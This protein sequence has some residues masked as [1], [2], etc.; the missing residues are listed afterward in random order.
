MKIFWKLINPP[1]LIFLLLFFLLYSSGS[2]FSGTHFRDDHVIVGINQHLQE[3]NFLLTLFKEVKNEF[4]GDGGIFSGTRFRPLFVFH[5]IVITKIFGINFLAWHIY[6]GFLA[7]LTAYFLY[8][9]ARLVRLRPKESFIFSLFSTLGPQFDNGFRLLNNET[10][11]I[12][13]LSISLVFSALG[14][15]YKKFSRQC[16]FL[17]LV[18]T[19]LMSLSKESFILFIP[20]LLYIKIWQYK[21]YN[22]TSWSST[23]R[24]NSLLIVALNSIFFL[25]S[26]YI[27]FFIGTSVGYAGI[28]GVNFSSF[29]KAAYSIT[30]FSFPL[31]IGIGFVFS[32]LLILR[33]CKSTEDFYF[34]NVNALTSVFT[35]FFLIV[36]PQ[37]ILYS[38]SDFS[39]RYLV[40]GILGYSFLLAF[41]YRF[42][43]DRSRILSFTFSILML[44]GIA[45][46]FNDTWKFS[47]QDAF[48]SKVA[49]EI[50]DSVEKDTRFDSPILVV[51]N[52]YID[53][54]WTHSIK[55][56][57]SLLK[58]RNNLYLSTYGSQKAD[59]LT[60]ALVKD[61]ENW[62]FLDPEDLNKS[63]ANRN[64]SNV[65]EKIQFQCIIVP[66]KLND[67]F[68][69]AS[70]EWFSFGNYK[71]ISYPREIPL[72]DFWMYLSRQLMLDKVAF[73]NGNASL[74]VNFILYIRKHSF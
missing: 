19:V 18:F 65:K 7:F 23:I 63:Y 37:I 62:L 24:K 49:R 22:Q 8:V 69:N 12:L 13:F 73:P 20:A 3:N 58:S 27:K 34:K 21:L 43:N 32:F 41:L 6:I 39:P 68:L 51:S 44:F 14:L 61:E 16:E 57:L 26:L 46:K 67:I 11:G 56:Y 59:Y 45:F 54:E 53:Y 28:E 10:I 55:I 71:K 48:E 30:E 1:L 50:L 4:L 31:L 17:F 70:P 15:K 42:I 29:F 74:P 64:L 5:S 25:E 52:P 33:K 2:L 36:I 72:S 60:N 38:K 35:I 66:A 40:P 9:Y 47:Y